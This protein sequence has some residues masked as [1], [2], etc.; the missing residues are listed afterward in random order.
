MCLLWSLLRA[1]TLDSHGDGLTS[2]WR[3]L[4]SNSALMSTSSSSALS[5]ARVLGLF[6]GKGLH[7]RRTAQARNF[8]ASLASLLTTAELSCAW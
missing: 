7:R 8:S 6:R 2:G 5:V 3:P 4:L 1:M